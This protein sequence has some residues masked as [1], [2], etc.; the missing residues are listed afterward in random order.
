MKE[1]QSQEQLKLMA[2]AVYEIRCLLS[3]ALGSTNNSPTSVR[4]AA[5]LAYALHNQALAILEGGEVF[6]VSAAKAAIKA[7]ER[8]VGSQYGDPF[9]LLSRDEIAEPGAAPNGGPA[10][11]VDKSNPTEGPP[12][13]S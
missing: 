5:H 13:V 4:L 1:A 3:D 6:D 9:N 7:G 10:T 8:T 11:P 2:A 12:P